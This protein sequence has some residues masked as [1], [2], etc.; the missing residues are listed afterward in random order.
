MAKAAARAQQQA[1]MGAAPGPR[2]PAK[3]RSRQPWAAGE[4]VQKAE[5]GGRVE[6]RTSMAKTRICVSAT[7]P[8]RRFV[9]GTERMQL[10]RDGELQ[11]ASSERGAG[12]Q[13][14]APF[15]SPCNGT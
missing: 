6:E 3:S 2:E 15:A 11:R 12:D 13:K 7:E 4:A 1:C 10:L 8:V 5:Y 9:V 14:N